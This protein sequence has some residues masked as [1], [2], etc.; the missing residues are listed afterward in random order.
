[1]IKSN[2]LR[3]TMIVILSAACFLSPKVC[4]HIASAQNNSNV[5]TV[6]FDVRARS[7]G[8]E[9]L[10]VFGEIHLVIQSH[11]LENGCI[12]YA[13]HHNAGNVIA[14]VDYERPPLRAWHAVMMRPDIFNISICNAEQCIVQGSLEGKIRIYSEWL[15][16]NLSTFSYYLGFLWNRCTNEWLFQSIYLYD[17]QI[18]EKISSYS[19]QTPNS[20][21]L[22]QNYP[23][24]FNPSTTIT[25]G[26]SEDGLVLLRVFDVHGCVVS[27][28]VNEQK[29]AGTYSVEFDGSQLPSGVYLYRLESNGQIRSNTMSLVK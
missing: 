29:S 1:M 9:D 25:Y 26:I 19:I 16:G 15:G 5:L 11:E 8:I 10:Q 23:N 13:I 18:I 4:N 3:Q 24:P 12:E 20:L 28:L 21:S 7:S 6:Q 17:W 22:Q 27:E 14:T 2:S